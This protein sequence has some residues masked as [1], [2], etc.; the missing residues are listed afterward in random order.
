MSPRLLS[1]SC[2][3]ASLIIAIAPNLWNVSVYSKRAFLQQPP[4]SSFES[5]EGNGLTQPLCP[6]SVV[7]RHS[8]LNLLLAAAKSNYVKNF[9]SGVGAIPIPDAE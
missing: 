5:R 9:V 4:S 8:N 6:S 1:K 2:S 3:I 7:K